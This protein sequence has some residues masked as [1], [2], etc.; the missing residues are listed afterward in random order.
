MINIFQQQEWHGIARENSAK[1]DPYTSYLEINTTP[2]RDRLLKMPSTMPY[3]DG[4]LP[5][6]AVYFSERG[7]Y[8]VAVDESGA[9]PNFGYN[10]GGEDI[11]T[12]VC[13]RWDGQREFD[14][15]KEVILMSAYDYANNKEAWSIRLY[16][17]SKT[18][19]WRV[20]AL[21]LDDTSTAVSIPVV[22]EILPGVWYYV[23]FLALTNYR[24]DV[25]SNDSLTALATGTVTSPFT[26]TAF[27][28]DYSLYVGGRRGLYD[29][30]LYK[31]AILTAFASESR[32]P[33]TFF[34]TSPTILH[35]EY[36]YDPTAS[37][38]VMDARHSVHPG[39]ATSS[40]TASDF[41]S[42]V[43]YPR[44][45]ITQVEAPV[46][47]LFE[48]EG[49]ASETGNAYEMHLAEPSLFRQRT[50]FMFLAD[51]YNHVQLLRSDDSSFAINWGG[52]TAAT[53]ALSCAWTP[54]DLSLGLPA[55]CRQGLAYTTASTFTGDRAENEWLAVEVI[56][57]TGTANNLAF[58][59]WDT[60]AW[61]AVATTS[62]STLVGGGIEPP[63]STRWVLG[64]TWDGACTIY[65][66]R[67]IVGNEGWRTA[68]TLVKFDD[69]MPPG[70]ICWLNTH[71]GDYYGDSNIHTAV[72][73]DTGDLAT[74]IIGIGDRVDGT[75][76]YRA[77][78]FVGRQRFTGYPYARGLAY[79]PEVETVEVAP[80]GTATGV[81]DS[82]FFEGSEVTPL[83]AAATNPRR[84]LANIG[85]LKY[86]TGAA[87]IQLA[88]PV[89]RQVGWH[90]P[91][92]FAFPTKDGARVLETNATL[93][94]LGELE[95]DT[96]YRVKCT[97]YDPVTG[98]E[99]NPFGPY[100]FITDTGSGTCGFSLEFYLCTFQDIVGQ[101]L[102]VYRFAEGTGAYHLEGSTII[103][104]YTIVGGRHT[105]SAF[106]TCAM[107]EDDLVLQKALELDN[108]APPEH[109][110]VTIWSHRAWY[111]DAVNPS[112]M[113]YSKEDFFGQVPPGNL[114]WTD[115]GLTGAI[116]GT[117]MG[118]GGL[119][120]LKERS[121]WIIPQGA[122]EASFSCEPLIPDVGCVSGSA[123][124]FANG[125]LWWASPGGIYAFDGNAPVN[126]SDRLEGVDRHVWSSNPRKTRCWHDAQNFRVVFACE[127][128]A[129]AID[130]RSGAASLMGI[131]YTCATSAN[132]SEYSGTVYGGAG[133][134]WK[135]VEGGAGQLLDS[136]GEHSAEYTDAFGSATEQTFQTSDGI[137]NFGWNL[138]NAAALASGDIHTTNPGEMTLTLATT[139]RRWQGAT[140]TG[141]F[142]YKRYYGNFDV[143][144][145]ITEI[146]D[147]S[148]EALLM[149]KNRGNDV[150][151]GLRCFKTNAT[152]YTVSHFAVTSG[153][154]ETTK[155][156]GTGTGPA[157]RF[158]RIGN[159]LTVHYRLAAAGA[160]AEGDTLD[161]STLGDM[162]F[163]GI[164]T[165]APAGGAGRY[166]TIASFAQEDA[167]TNT[168]GPLEIATSLINW[169]WHDG[170]YSGT[171]PVGLN[172]S[173]TQPLLN[174]SGDV[175]D[176]GYWHTDTLPVG[177]LLTFWDTDTGHIWAASPAGLSGSMV[178][179]LLSMKIGHA[180]LDTFFFDRTPIFYR[181]NDIT[182][183]RKAD[184]KEIKRLDFVTGKIEGG[185]TAHCL[186]GAC[187][188]SEET[189]M[190]SSGT[191]LIS[192][193]SFYQIP[194]RVR[195]YRFYWELATH[196]AA[197]IPDV[198]ELRIHYRPIRPRGRAH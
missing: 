155:T 160:W 177:R 58:W 55:V 171:L 115:E 172:I 187:I 46:G 193:N 86:I 156:Y 185:G 138:L 139:E 77:S 10:A 61:A 116:L 148:C 123:A 162:A 126:Y 40:A 189:P 101:T 19:R 37:L 78:P 65:D 56:P 136:E 89:S 3:I 170:L 130:T 121:L 179:N 54:K 90:P 173:G 124:V 114:L 186:V 167:S 82:Y 44:P 92:I 191:T 161:V 127:G 195:G 14:G 17:H 74:R 81:C 192:A 73:P 196:S 98:N 163:I 159:N 26:R 183:G 76:R 2:G 113:Y 149:A 133:G 152:E 63:G 154:V 34:H 30:S 1:K 83:I 110:Y 18:D 94:G 174:C 106:F 8:L 39:F 141:G 134:I 95:Y 43:S 11:R 175:G 7:Q 87:P 188:H 25:Y 42:F 31:G 79:F 108:Y 28:G 59:R 29:G 69:K 99:S 35:P 24:V 181:S 52:T 45:G 66:F 62:A 13:F 109:S 88:A 147:T 48:A 53:M 60:S 20:R 97:L 50:V 176:Y 182:L 153:G 112:R 16:L 80:D 5:S 120:V 4:P 184:G 125:I 111:V 100:R 84:E 107:D 178:F 32:T 166:I 135:E 68:H 6:G 194:A 71:T 131:P 169:S 103:S 22:A 142:V 15:T 117:T 122:E 91:E 132:T 93:D 38:A 96:T 128:A 33:V 12:A 104:G 21:V 180:L 146:S 57:D 140:V 164:G 85:H 143:T 36:A 23:R 118:F 49:V 105:C 41:V 9:E 27:S 190:E 67:V 198:K 168:H 197:S 102:R 144:L 75:L 157:L 72:L 150:R 137:M 64:E 151:F 165:G 158:V 119:V 129:I 47:H 145:P 51:L 70:M